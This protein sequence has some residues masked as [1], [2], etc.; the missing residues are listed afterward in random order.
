[1]RQLTALSAE[2]RKAVTPFQAK[3]YEAL[4]HVEQGQV[5]TYK[6]I[7]RFIDCSSSQAIGQALKRNPFAPGIPCHRVV[8]SDLS[9]G[10]FCGSFSKAPAK[11][12]MLEKEGVIFHQNGKGDWI[13]DSSCVYEF[14]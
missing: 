6:R 14:N 13:V 8:K 3:V 10:G 7:G 2:Q 4:L 1:M 12:A 9:L 11:L 5:T